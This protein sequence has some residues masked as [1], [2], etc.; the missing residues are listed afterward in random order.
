M[1]T[2]EKKEDK[3]C[4]ILGFIA[5]EMK[6]GETIR[7]TPMSKEIDIHVGTLIKQFNEWE[8]VKDSPPYKNI[9]NTIGI[10]LLKDKEGAIIGIKKITEE[11]FKKE[12]RDAILNINEKIDRLI[13]EN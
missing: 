1:K 2:K 5:G 13:K 4:R 11:N 3:I 12:I 8:K 6:E 9:L 7:P 10:D